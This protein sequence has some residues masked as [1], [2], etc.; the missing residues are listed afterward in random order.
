MFHSQLKPIKYIRTAK[1]RKSNVSKFTSIRK[2]FVTRRKLKFDS[3]PPRP[4]NFLAGHETRSLS[5]YPKLYP[6]S[7][8]NSN[9]SP[10]LRFVAF[11]TERKRERERKREERETREE[12]RR[13]VQ[14]YKRASLKITSRRPG[15]R[16][17]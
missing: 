6:R 16:V 7:N 14:I 13:A 10:L 8:S 5:R 17:S 2:F 9:F 3:P 12:E 4:Q 1:Q 15:S 11:H